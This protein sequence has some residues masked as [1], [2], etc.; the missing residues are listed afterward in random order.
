MRH[1]SAPDAPQADAS[2]RQLLAAITRD[3]DELGVL[4]LGTPPSDG[5]LAIAA[6]NILQA[7]RLKAFLRHRPPDAVIGGSILVFRLDAA[8]IERAL[9]GPPAELD[10]QSWFERERYGTADELVRQGRRH[11]D[12]ER[13]DQAVVTFE[14][15]TRLYPGDPRA[16]DGLAVACRSL[17]DD[18]RAMRAERRCERIRARLAAGEAER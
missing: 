13:A 6:F 9:H 7:G 12:E 14:S 11:L 5:A 18:D 3:R 8:E 16:W 15:A 17:G 4:S 1:E 10:D 2:A